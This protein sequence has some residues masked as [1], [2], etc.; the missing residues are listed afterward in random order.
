MNYKTLK[1]RIA[2]SLRFNQ[3]MY[4][5]LLTKHVSRDS[6][7]LDAG[8]GRH[9]LPPWRSAAEADLMHNASFA[10]GCDA[11]EP[12]LRLHSTLPSRVVAN[13]EHLPFKSAS[14]NLITTNMVVEH[15][16]Q[17]LRVFGE[18]ARV[19]KPGGRVIVHTPYAHSYIALGSLILPEWFK[20][21]LIRTLDGRDEPEVFPTRYRANTPRRLL[22]LMTRVGLRQEHCR[23]LASD[24]V[25][26]Q[27]HPLLAALELLYIRLSLQPMFRRLRVSMLGVFV[28]ASL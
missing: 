5:A 21:R 15:L 6:V 2:P 20:L 8:C 18:F 13:L 11:D 12:S 27:A 23:L 26:A 10:I 3:D 17:P 14:M 9:S 1:A 19:L 28:K 7:W 22:E 4:E 25:F 24:A 16:E